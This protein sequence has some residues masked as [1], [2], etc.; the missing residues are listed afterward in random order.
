MSAGATIEITGA[1]ARKIV[2]VLRKKTGDR[3]QVID[4]AAQH[5]A[6]TLEIDNRVVRASLGEPVVAA[7][8][9][10]FA[11]TVAQAVPKGQKMDFVIEKLTELGVAEIVPVYSER[12]VVEDVGAGK[13]ERW[14]R[15]AQTAA[16]QCGRDSIPA[17]RD[18]QQL[19]QIVACF[20]QFD[21]VLFP[22][23]LAGGGNLRDTL[24]G[25]VAGARSI[26]VVIGPEGGFSSD[27][28]DAARA[29]GAHLVSL[30]PRILRTET[31]ALVVAAI[32][33]YLG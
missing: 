24:P 15:L 25:L 5:F 9:E 21:L 30:G 7:H 4:S 8:P 2:T 33:N 14:R 1:D 28:A 22:W 17:V 11:L 31:A 26:L 6:A 32:L 12:T 19:S 10:R 27:E 29:A 13:L 23:E 20:A 3:I 18:P 16:Q